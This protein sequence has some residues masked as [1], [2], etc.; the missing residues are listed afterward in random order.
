MTLFVLTPDTVWNPNAFG[1]STAPR[2]VMGRIPL[3]PRRG[4]TWCCVA[5]VI[6]ENAFLRYLA[7]L[8]PFVVAMLVWPDMALPISQAPLPM[9]I[10]IGIVEMRLLRIPRG[11]RATVTTQEDAERSLD[12]LMFRGRRVLTQIAAHRGQEAGALHLVV[13]QSDLARVPALTVASVQADSGRRRLVA[14][15]DQE[16]QIICNGL[17]DADFTAEDLLRANH[18]EGNYMRA[19]TFET[20]GVS[21]HARLAA[22]LARPRGQERLA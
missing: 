9:L 8:I 2:K 7:A 10:M 12:T 14:L 17:F 4:I 3:L 22:A 13:E 18:R 5:R 11:K 19:V 6:F 21:A 16:R 20:R 15:D 1:F